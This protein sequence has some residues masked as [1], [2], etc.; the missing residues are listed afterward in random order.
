M[1]KKLSKL[2]RMKVCWESTFLQGSWNY[3]KLQNG[4]W[5]YLMVPAIKELYPDKE[6]QKA[7]L[8]RHMAF[9]NTHPYVASPIIGVTLKLEEDRANG[10]A[11]SDEQ[12]DGIKV[13]MMGPLAGIG[14]PVFWF[15]LRPIIGAICATLAITGK[16][17]GPIL[18]F[19]LWSAIRLSFM[20]YTQ[21]LGYKEGTNILNVF[22]DDFLQKITQGASV[23]GMFILGALVIRCVNVEFIMGQSVLDTLLPGMVSV[24]L[25]LLCCRLLKKKVSPILLIIGIFVICVLL[26][27]VGIL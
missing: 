11:V 26:H 4:G 7:A 10:L 12:I 5:A 18:F 20:W 25:T 19:V 3:E 14:D 6:Q 16:T 13:G 1:A 17:I 22:S 23:A 9:F 21:E 27:C 15:T 24:L 2:T 8:Q